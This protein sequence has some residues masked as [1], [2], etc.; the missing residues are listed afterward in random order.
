MALPDQRCAKHLIDPTGADV[1]QVT[2][3]DRVYHDFSGLGL[4]SK[5]LIRA[6]WRLRKHYWMILR[7]STPGAFE[8][9]RLPSGMSKNYPKADVKTSSIKVSC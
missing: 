4:N 5:A 9:N 2:A 3:R 6:T 7:P 1:R 8:T